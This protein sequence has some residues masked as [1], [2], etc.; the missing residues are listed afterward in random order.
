M[1][2]KDSFEIL[3]IFLINRC[4]LISY[5]FLAFFQ[6]YSKCQILLV[7]PILKENQEQNEKSASVSLLGMI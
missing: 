1:L 3:K 2:K 7:I 4:S 6:T 5:V